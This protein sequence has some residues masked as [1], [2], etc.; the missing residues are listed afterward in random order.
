[1]AFRGWNNQH[2]ARFNSATSSDFIDFYEGYVDDKIRKGAQEPSHQTFAASSFRCD[3]RSW[4][5]IRGVQPDS[6][7]VPDKALNFTAEIGTACH[8]II[9]G[10]LKAALG[11]DW[12]NVADYINSIDF[13]YEYS[14]K[15]DD[16]GFEHQI[17]IVDPPIRFACDG[18]VRWKDQYYLLEI[19]TSEFSS[20]SDLVDPKPQHVDQV[21]CYATLLNLHGILFLYQDRQY[22]GLKCYEVKMSDV[23][24]EQVKERFRYV[25]DMVSKNLAPE[26]LPVGD[27]WCTPSMCPYYKKCQE[28]GR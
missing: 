2:L 8:R 13:P 28:Y 23:E 7:K 6:V 9:Q 20:W 22:G 12:V 26:A 16:D 19:K 14:I 25:L 18:V 1:M 11:D 5:R 17:E 21:K 15:S 27:S 10:N 24:M 4:F 3:R